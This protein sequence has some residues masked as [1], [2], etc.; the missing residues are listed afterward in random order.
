[1]AEQ[2]ITKQMTTKIRK[3]KCT[4]NK[5]K[6]DENQIIKKRCM[7]LLTFINC[8]F[9]KIEIF[10]FFEERESWEVGH[11]LVTRWL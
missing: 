4:I 9:G 3:N 8:T 6:Y 11:E 2:W 7:I 10:N 1:M 5:K